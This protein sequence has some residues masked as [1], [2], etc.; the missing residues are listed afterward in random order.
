MRVPAA[1]LEDPGPGVPFFWTELSKTE[2]AEEVGAV[3][4]PALSIIMSY[5]SNPHYLLMVGAGW[6]QHYIL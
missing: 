2:A 5:E 4:G 6:S 1:A 3:A